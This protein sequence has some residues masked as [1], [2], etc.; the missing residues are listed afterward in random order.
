MKTSMRARYQRCLTGHGAAGGHSPALQLVPG[1]HIK[2]LVLC[3]SVARLPQRFDPKPGSD[4]PGETV[5]ASGHEDLCG[6]L[7]SGDSEFHVL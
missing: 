6:C 7:V 4:D 3:A 1:C 2:K 5:Q